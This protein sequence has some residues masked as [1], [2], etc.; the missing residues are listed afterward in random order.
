M[1]STLG[2]GRIQEPLK[3]NDSRFFKH[4]VV[5]LFSDRLMRKRLKGE[6]VL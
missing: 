6:N 2:N 5:C 1:V 4:F 3:E